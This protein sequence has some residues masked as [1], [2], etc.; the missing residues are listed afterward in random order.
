MAGRWTEK[1]PG[2]PPAV[3]EEEESAD[4][5]TVVFA[6][7]EGSAGTLPAGPVGAGCVP[8]AAVEVG[9]VPAVAVRGAVE[10][11]VWILGS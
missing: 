4:K 8:V 7:A 9:T 10:A 11:P 5:V 2:I 6:A 1:S 3:V